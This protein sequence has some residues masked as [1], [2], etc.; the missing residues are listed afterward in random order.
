M[1]K[2][3]SI[4]IKSWNI[5]G[6]IDPPGPIQPHSKLLSKQ[7]FHSYH[8]PTQ[9][10]AGRPDLKTVHFARSLTLISPPYSIICTR[11]HNIC[12]FFL[13]PPLLCRFSL[14][15]HSLC[16]HLYS[17]L[18]PL[19]VSS[20]YCTH[21]KFL[22][23]FSNNESNHTYIFYTKYVVSLK[24]FANAGLVNNVLDGSAFLFA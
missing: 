20:V 19:C 14:A 15:Q 3:V 2:I 18:I 10:D 11:S 12:F 5:H 13:I 7:H 6:S 21:F 17:P 4:F 16:T 9:F 24:A 23:S 1:W 22:F 8:P